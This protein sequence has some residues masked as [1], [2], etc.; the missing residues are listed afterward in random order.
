M[1][2]DTA[3]WILV[4]CALLMI[5]VSPWICRHWKKTANEALAAAESWK[6]RATSAES[7]LQSIANN[8]SSGQPFEMILSHGSD[9][10]NGVVILAYG[11]TS[12]EGVTET[13]TGR[14]R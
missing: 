14:P 5:V 8:I 13:Q 4:E 10:K 11:S 2:A 3:N 12:F 9:H 7:M 6:T 1:T